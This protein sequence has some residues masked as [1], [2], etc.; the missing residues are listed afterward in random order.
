MRPSST[1]NSEPSK[2]SKLDTRSEKFAW[3]RLAALF[4]LVAISLFALDRFARHTIR[5]SFARQTLSRYLPT[6]IPHTVFLGSSLTDAGILPQLLDSL[7]PSMQY[8]N[9]ALAGLNTPVYYQLLVKNFILPQAHPK[10]IVVEASGFPFSVPTG[11]FHLEGNGERLD[12]LMSE[13]MEYSDFKSAC[14]GFPGIIPTLQFFMHKHWYAYHYRLELQGKVTERLF[15]HWPKP[16]AN[17]NNPYKMVEGA[18]ELF[19]KMA[20]NIL[21]DKDSSKVKSDLHD[22][23]S[24]FFGLAQLSRAHQVQLIMLTPPCPPQ[25]RVLE[26]ESVYRKYRVEFDRICD[27]LAIVHIDLSHAPNGNPYT[28]S[29]GI[30]LD[31]HGARIF[32]L[33]FGSFLRKQAN[34]TW[35]ST[36]AP[37]A[38]LAPNSGE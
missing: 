5:T 21:A 25:D 17:R 31:A 7:N 11:K 35:T 20:K 19:Q 8:F 34:G 26:N 29:D 16:P 12:L 2:D 28:F 14:G 6:R 9:L 13:L 10:F 27:S 30:H 33:A 36:I 24:G 3:L 23:R 37:K 18:A 1:F 15:K 32:T 22:P 38:T 4:G